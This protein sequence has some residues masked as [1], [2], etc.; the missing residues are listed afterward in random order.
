MIIDPTSAAPVSLYKLLIGAVVPRPIAFVSTVSDAGVLNLAPFSFFTVA[1]CNPPVLCF[2]PMVNFQ[3]RRRDTLINIERTRE[4]VV[5]VVSE[6]F[7]ERMNEA[8]ADVPPEID[9]FELSGLT[10][11]ASEVV[12]P[13][14]VK[15]AHVNFECQLIEA[16]SFGA[17]PLS[18]TLVLGAVVRIHVDDAY[19]DDFRIDPERLRAIG[20]MGG[21]TYAR[22]TDRFEMARPE[23]TPAAR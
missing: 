18:G 5:N 6:E 17:E 13:P 7:A 15:E 4:F 16:R 14:R 20:R 8:S 23:V 22:T 21:S 1:S 12:R 10:A 9:E 19:C 11:I 3:G 2:T